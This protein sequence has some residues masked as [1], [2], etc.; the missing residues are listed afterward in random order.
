MKLILENWRRYLTE[1]LLAEFDRGDEESIMAQQDRFTVSYE[2]E[3]AYRAKDGEPDEESLRIDR[4][5]GA[6][7]D[8]AK[9]QDKKEK[10]SKYFPN[11][12]KKWESKLKFELDP[13]VAS[14]IEFSMHNPLYMS[15]LNEA[16]E[17]LEDFFD[18]YDKQRSFHRGE[19]YNFYF[20]QATGLHTNVG[21]VDEEGK[22]IKEYDL[23]KALL[24]LNK[25]F[26]EGK[27]QRQYKK[28]KGKVVSAEY[29]QQAFPDREGSQ[30]I[31][32]IKS[33]IKEKLQDEFGKDGS[34]LSATV[35]RLYKQN[36]LG[37]LGKKL[38]E[39]VEAETD[40]MMA[41]A[42]GF[43]Y[44]YVKELGYVEF[45]YPGGKDVTYKK[46]RYLTL[47][48][49]YIVKQAVDPEFKKEEYE[50]QLMKLMGELSGRKRADEPSAKLVTDFFKKGHIYK[51]PVMGGWVSSAG[52]YPHGQDGV[53]NYNNHVLK[54][55]ILGPMG[56][57]DQIV[58][59]ELLLYKGLLG[60]PKT[61]WTKLSDEEKRGRRRPQLSNIR[62]LFDVVAVKRLISSGEKT[63]LE[64][65]NIYE[66]KPYALPF[67]YAEKAIL[68]GKIREVV[69]EWEERVRDIFKNVREGVPPVPDW[70]K[71]P[72]EEV[73]EGK[74]KV[75]LV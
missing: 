62:V 20:S 28:E 12:M 17:F 67:A 3:L 40:P 30:F 14:G 65:P 11:F 36:K 60:I 71:P 50:N 57:N 61:P 59:H 26:A 37:D 32:D 18:D 34:R 41:K 31:G 22:P 73:T 68:D 24:F 45:R 2:I 53:V 63:E 52:Q 1:E 10:L 6:A 7:W 75:K 42:T 29:T 74:I 39:F 35:E 51:V 5:R 16:F 44:N 43:N 56:S 38:G 69:P 19:P 48:Y 46:V 54:Y 15:G 33:K 25:E 8:K 64:N 72:G 9:L 55:N 66:I 47:Y 4:L 58:N 21:Y 13:S 49:A 27:R 70:R 23:M